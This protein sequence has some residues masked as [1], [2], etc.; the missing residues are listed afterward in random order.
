MKCFYIKSKYSKDYIISRFEAFREYE[1]HNYWNIFDFYESDRIG[2]HTYI[3]QNRV[4]GYFED[5]TITRLG[6]LQRI[7]PWFYASVKSKNGVSVIKGVI[8]PHPVFW[9]LFM[10][11][12]LVSIIDFIYRGGEAFIELLFMLFVFYIFSKTEIQNQKEIINWMNNN[13]T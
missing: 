1:N 12:L 11:S 13:F 4:K 10:G 6:D 3:N 7:K 2:I 5:G 8:F 9:I